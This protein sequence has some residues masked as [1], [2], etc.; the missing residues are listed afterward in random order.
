MRRASHRPGSIVVPIAA[1][2][3]ALTLVA[4]FAALGSVVEKA[5]VTWVVDGDTISV[6]LGDRRERVRLLGV[7]TPEPNDVREDYRQAAYDARDHLIALLKG[8][9][10]LLERDPRADDRD[11]HGRLLRYVVLDGDNVNL[12][13]VREGWGFALLR[14]PL[15]KKEEFRRAESDARRARRGVW[16]LPDGRR[17]RVRS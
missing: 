6:R 15:E 7:D 16:Q 5:R 8:K 13:L 4:A 1:V 17:R 14:Y 9:T 2:T 10:V 12:A 3:L 11:K